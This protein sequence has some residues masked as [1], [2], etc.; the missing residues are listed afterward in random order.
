VPS[1]R[2]RLLLLLTVGFAVLVAATVLVVDG[3]LVRAATV[4]FDDA[5]LARART[6]IALTEQEGGRIELDYVPLQ[7]PEF[8]REERPDHFEFWLDDGTSLLRSRR[9]EGHLPRE[10]GTGNAAPR[11]I[12]LAGGRRARAVQLQ[13][14]PQEVAAA[15]EEDEESGDAAGADAVPRQLTLVVARGRERLDAVV[16]RMRLALL[17]GGLGL[18]LLA[19]LLAWRAV[20]QALR[21][22]DHVAEQV[23]HLDSENLGARVTL[24]R[25]PR[26]LAPV[27]GQ[28]NALL[29]RLDSSFARERRFAGNVAHELRTPLAELRSLATM[30]GRWPEDAAAVQG[31]FGDVGA[32][33]GR[34]EGVIADLLLL[35]RCQAGVEHIELS[36]TRLEALIASAWHPLEGAAAAQGLRFSLDMPADLVVPSDA[37]KLGILFSNLLGNAVSY[38]PPHSEIRCTGARREGRYE[39]EVVNEAA[40]RPED[41]EKVAEPFWRGDASR[42]SPE[43]AGLGLAL[44]TAIARLLRLDVQFDQDAG[45]RFRVRLQGA[46]GP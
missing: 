5:L 44:V 27:V 37:T 20:A 3:M 26:E 22:L 40:L 19:G 30:G 32:I 16:A 7:M 2:R 21:P 35:A 46:A 9:L 23:R 29:E 24:S 43:H 18:V 1:I 34:M 41:L 31:Y 42:T 13:W 25:T 8:E 28:L 4:E 15:E 17:G 12:V 38:A 6:F 36:P 14:A 10:A 39:V 33:A 11:D 45:G